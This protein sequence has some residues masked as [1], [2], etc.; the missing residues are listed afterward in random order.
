MILKDPNHSGINDKF[1][2]IKLRP[3]K[4]QIMKNDISSMFQTL[5]N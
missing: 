1:K 5:H 4:A 2:D 3:D